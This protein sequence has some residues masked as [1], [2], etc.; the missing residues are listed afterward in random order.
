MLLN[1]FFSGYKIINHDDCSRSDFTDHIM[2]SNTVHRNPHH[3]LIDDQASDA[4]DQKHEKFFDLIGIFIR[5]KHIFNAQNI[6]HDNRNTEG[7]A[8]GYQII[9]MHDL[10]QKYHDAVIDKEAQE[11]DKSEF[12]NLR[13]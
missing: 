10:C 3:N 12:Y 6:I 11:P 7:T 2:N 9:D 1:E 13:K 5:I 4:E 8:A